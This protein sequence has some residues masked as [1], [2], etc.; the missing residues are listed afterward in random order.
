MLGKLRGMNAVAAK[1]SYAELEAKVV[2]LEAEVARLSALLE[3]AVREGKRQAAPFR[4][5]EA[6]QKPKR[7]GRK[8][9]QDHG[10]HGHRP[11]PPSIDETLEAPAPENGSECGEP[12]APEPPLEQFQTD[13]E[14]RPIFRKFVIGRG[15]CPR[16]GK[17]FRGR[18]PQQCSDAVGAAGSGLGPN[19]QAAAAFLRKQGAMSDGAVAEACE[20]IFGVKVT[21]G[22]ICQAVARL[23]KKLGP[24]VRQ[25]D[26]HRRHAPMVVPD[27]TGFRLGGRNAW[28][29]VLVTPQATRYAIDRS[30]GAEVAAAL[31]G[32]DYEGW[33]VHD[34]DAAYERFREALHQQCNT[35]GLRRCRELRARAVGAARRFPAQ[36]KKLFQSALKARDRT[37]AGPPELGVRLYEQFTDRLIVLTAGPRANPENERFARHLHR[38]AAAWF[39]YLLEPGLD[40]TN[41]R[42]EQAVRLLVR[43]RKVWGGV[44]TEAGARTHEA[45]CSLLATLRQQGLAPVGYFADVLRR[46]PRPLPFAA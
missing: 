37:R 36:V 20:Q 11:P 29:H 2:R 31:L 28:G 33:M 25:I 18:H 44:R 30:R 13:I 6:K 27:E 24:Q 5:G 38:H 9:G 21:R 7:P 14:P 40:A 17:V 12:L 10:A 41:W 19:L 4:T 43:Q 16:C 35:H 42:A 45:V 46:Q 39:A 1:P 23:G 34:G 26:E 3:R 15:R 22:A 8:K 32:W